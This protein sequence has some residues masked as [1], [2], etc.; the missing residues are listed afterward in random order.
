MKFTFKQ[1]ILNER[2]RIE[3]AM[4][5]EVVEVFFIFNVD[6]ET[7]RELPGFVIT[8]NKGVDTLAQRCSFRTLEESLSFIRDFVKKTRDYSELNK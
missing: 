4:G 8:S 6:A 7:G 1:S 5:D 3:A 2:V